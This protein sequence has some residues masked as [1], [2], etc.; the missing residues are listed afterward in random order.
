MKLVRTT[1]AVALAAVACFVAACGSESK[2]AVRT[3]TPTATAPAA[4]TP[5]ATRTI[6]APASTSTPLVPSETTV[7]RTPTAPGAQTTATLAADRKFEL[8]PIDGAEIVVEESFPVQ[9]AVHIT[10]GLPSGCAQFADAT[11]SRN[12][13]EIT[14]TVRNTL[15]AN[16]QIACTQIYGT[17]ETTVQLGSDFARGTT[18]RVRVNDRTLQFTAQ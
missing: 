11:V 6:V 5:T 3:A 1:A 9:Y 14:I 4:T 10:S 16:G 15:P 8:A 7:A 12:G 13:D 17:H 2:P 18:Y